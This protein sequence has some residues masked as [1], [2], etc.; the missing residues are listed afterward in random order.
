MDNRKALQEKLNVCYGQLTK[1]WLASSPNQLV[2]AA[3]EIAAAQFIHGNLVNSI[4]EAD[5]VV[6]LQ[7]YSPLE[8][9][10][11]KWIEENGSGTVHDDDLAHCVFSLSVEQQAKQDQD[12]THFGVTLH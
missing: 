1:Q 4:T 11:D 5:A 2:A 6:L 12:A 10:R 3:E 7:Y 8:V 9:V